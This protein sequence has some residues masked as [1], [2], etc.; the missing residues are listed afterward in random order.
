MTTEIVDIKQH[1]VPQ[2]YLK[3]FGEMIH[4]FDKKTENKF[5]TIPKN[6]AMGKNFYGGEIK[7]APSLEQSLGKIESD[8]AEAIQELIKKAT[9]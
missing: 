9:N 8:F 5:K 7:G 4:A 3:N 2:F 1:Y 6:I